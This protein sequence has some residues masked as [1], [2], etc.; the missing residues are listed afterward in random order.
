MKENQEKTKIKFDFK[1]MRWQGLTV[2]Q[3][4]LWEFLYP[5]IDVI[6][7]L[8]FEMVR[9]LDRQVKSGHINKIARKKDWKKFITNWL[10]SEQE[11]AVWLRRSQE[12][13]L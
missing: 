10:K 1:S 13:A 6:Q 8:K 12:N 3:I 2:E 5:D 7:H 9:W 11:K 4:Q